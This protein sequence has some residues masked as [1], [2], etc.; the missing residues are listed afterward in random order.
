MK[1]QKKNNFMEIGWLVNYEKTQ[2]T[3]YQVFFPKS[4]GVFLIKRPY[5]FPFVKSDF[6]HVKQQQKYTVE[7]L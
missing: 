6:H 3:I 2:V 5:L 4:W 1:L 7:P